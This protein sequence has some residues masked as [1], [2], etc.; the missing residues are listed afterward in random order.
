MIKTVAVGSGAC[1][2]Y[3]G[4]V[5]DIGVDAFVTGELKHHEFLYLFGIAGYDRPYRPFDLVAL[6]VRI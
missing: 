3:T 1:G 5:C 2:E 6:L 4:L